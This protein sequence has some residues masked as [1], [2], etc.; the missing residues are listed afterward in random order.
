I[1]EQVNNAQREKN[2]LDNVMAEATNNLIDQTRLLRQ[3]LSAIFALMGTPVVEQLTEQVRSLRENV[4][5][6]YER[7]DSLSEEQLRSIAITGEV[8]LG[9]VGMTVAFAALNSIIGIVMSGFR[10]LAT[11]GA[12]VFS[13]TILWIAGITAAVLLLRR[14]WDE[15][16]GGM[17][18]SAVSAMDTVLS[19]WESV[20]AFFVGSEVPVP[21]VGPGAQG[22]WTTARVGGLAGFTLPSLAMPTW[23]DVI[24]AAREA[25]AAAWAK[26]VAFF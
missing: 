12:F 2:Y 20:K 13:P 26:V 23:A 6:L 4:Q 24:N 17:K 25:A 22:E 7:F 5:I 1:L 3:T 11:I 16:W 15:N 9:I 14:G 18:T 10:T 19:K 21:P 8:V